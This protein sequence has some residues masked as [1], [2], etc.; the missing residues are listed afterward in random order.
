MK[1]GVLI[2][3]A[4]LGLCLVVALFIAFRKHANCS[5]SVVNAANRTTVGVSSAPDHPNED[6][7]TEDKLPVSNKT[8]T[9]STK[10][11]SPV[12]AHI[13][14]EEQLKRK[15]NVFTTSEKY[16]IVVMTYKRDDLLKRFLKHYNQKSFPELKKI[17]V[18]WNNI[19]VPLYEKEFVSSISNAAPITF[20]KPKTN[21]LR[22]KMTPHPEVTTNGEEVRV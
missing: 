7:K 8:N 21:T 22:S 5:L 12:E 1:K 17:V 6:H 3:N 14:K 13:V 20:I 19:G 2:Y 15:W 11:R 4:L 16:T 9:T 10:P 18:I